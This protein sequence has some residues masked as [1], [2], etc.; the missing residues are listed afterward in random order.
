MNPALVEAII[1]YH[2]ARKYVSKVH[3]VHGDFWKE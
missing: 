2:E 3:D 1:R